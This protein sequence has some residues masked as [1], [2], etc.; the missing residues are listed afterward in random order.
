VVVLGVDPENKRISLGL[1]QTQED[2]WDQLALQYAPGVESKGKVVRV[3]EDG[4][5][6]DLGNDVEGFVPRSQLDVPANDDV[7]NYIDDDQELD[8]RVIEF[9]AANRRI[10]NAVTSTL[11]RLPE[12]KLQARREAAAAATPVTEDAEGGAEP[13][14]ASSAAADAEE[15]AAG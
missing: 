8:L 6:V 15:T 2:P 3:L 1:K 11:T 7:A 10:V 4:I 13:V 12:E 5:V 14:Q 9:D